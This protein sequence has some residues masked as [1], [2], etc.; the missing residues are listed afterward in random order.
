MIEE[1]KVYPITLLRGLSAT[2]RNRLTSNGI[3]LLKQLAEKNIVGLRRQTGIRKQ[4]LAPLV[5]GAKAI[6]SGN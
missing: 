2:T 3:I 4:K 5:D 6:L 1:K